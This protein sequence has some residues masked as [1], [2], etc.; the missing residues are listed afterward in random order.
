MKATPGRAQPSSLPAAPQPLPGLRRSQPKNCFPKH[1]SSGFTA[2]SLQ[3]AACSAALRSK[4]PGGRLILN[5]GAGGGP[6]PWLCTFP[7]SLVPGSAQ[8][9]SDQGKGPLPTGPRLE[10][11]ALSPTASQRQGQFW[12]MCPARGLGNR[13]QGLHG[14]GH[15]G[16]P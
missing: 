15:S 9:P 7:R 1:H 16:K 8:L 2:P 4:D 11:T 5:P 6:L 10:S 12:A 14:N 13:L 3:L